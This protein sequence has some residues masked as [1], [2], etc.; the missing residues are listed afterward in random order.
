[1]ISKQT[2]IEKN[3]LHKS[4][5]VLQSGDSKFVISSRTNTE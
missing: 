4:R 2:L 1:M 3:S 5:T